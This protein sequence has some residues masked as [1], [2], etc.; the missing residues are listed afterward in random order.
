MQFIETVSQSGLLN[1]SLLVKCPQVHAKSIY[2]MTQS[3]G[4]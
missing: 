2:D 3:T 1:H 4:T